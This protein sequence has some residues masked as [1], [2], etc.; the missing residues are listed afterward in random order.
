ML[1]VWDG[2]GV[3]LPMAMLFSVVAIGTVAL[4]PGSLL[5]IWAIRLRA[6]TAPLGFA[7]PG[8]LGS[9]QSGWLA[10]HPLRV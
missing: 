10:L 3:V 7:A 9:Y 2:I 6:R 5:C 1:K 4:T 8:S